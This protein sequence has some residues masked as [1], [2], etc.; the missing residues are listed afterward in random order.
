VKLG[1]IQTRP[2]TWRPHRSDLLDEFQDLIDYGFAAQAHREVRRDLARIAL[3]LE[4]YH[5]EHGSYPES[6]AVVV[7]T[8][9]HDLPSD[10]FVGRPYHYLC[11]P[12]TDIYTLYSVGVNQ[13]DDGGR[14]GWETGDL[15]WHAPCCTSADPYYQRHLRFYGPP[16]KK[17]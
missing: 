13:R 1:A 3:A 11:E 4:R 5:A 9:L 12:D 15:V 2:Q 10:P 16:E 17:E 7:S 8:Y 14:P 6:L